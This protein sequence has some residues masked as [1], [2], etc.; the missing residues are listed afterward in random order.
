MQSAGRV[1]MRCL[2]PR[3]F[4]S[5][6]EDEVG[7]LCLE[8]GEGGRPGRSKAWVVVEGG[9][10]LVGQYCI[11]YDGWEDWCVRSVLKGYAT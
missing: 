5:L 8:R 11:W 3:E 6:W 10:D 7:R 9:V 1:L 2:S 4:G